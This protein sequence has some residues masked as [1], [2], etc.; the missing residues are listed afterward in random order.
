MSTDAPQPPVPSAEIR[1]L[2]VEMPIRINGYD[3]DVMGIVH[4][5]VYPRWFEDLRTLFLDL[6][7]PL[8]GMLQQQQCPT[9]LTTHV[10]YKSPLTIFDKP[11]G[12]LWLTEVGKARWRIAAEIVTEQAL[13]CTGWQEGIILDLQK[14]KPVRLPQYLLDRYH[15]DRGRLMGT[16]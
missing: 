1:P 15:A 16:T 2:L 13:H 8:D 7:W 10:E 3:I 4:N 9:I 11:V 12:R 6:H 5:L 14:R